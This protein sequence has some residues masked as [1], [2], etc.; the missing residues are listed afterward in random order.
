[1]DATIAYYGW[2]ITGVTDDAVVPWSYTVGLVEG[3]DHPEL[4]VVGLADDDSGHLFN[5]HGRQV[6][7]AAAS[8]PGPSPRSTATASPDEE[9]DALR[10][11]AAAVGCRCR[12][13]PAGPSA[14]VRRPAG[15][16]GSACT[17]ADLITTVHAEALDVVDLPALAARL[18]EIP[19]R[20]STSGAWAPTRARPRARALGTDACPD[21]WPKAA[22][23]LQ[24]QRCCSRS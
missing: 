13:P 22:A 16:P 9:Q 19:P 6:P 4:L 17:A 2:A 8:G 20:C 15:A 1:M 12:W 7:M 10:E 5:G 18:L 3:F 21:L 23:L 11:R 14:R 24:S